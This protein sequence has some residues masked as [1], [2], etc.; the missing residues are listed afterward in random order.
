MTQIHITGAG[1]I[2]SNEVVLIEKILLDHGYIVDVRD[3][4]LDRN[5]TYD[6]TSEHMKKYNSEC[7]PATI[8][9]TT[10]HLPWGG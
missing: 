3:P 10:N 1:G 9:I 7:G 2:I 6:E 4:H 8:V 5:R